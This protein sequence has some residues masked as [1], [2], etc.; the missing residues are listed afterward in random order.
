MLKHSF[1][2]LENVTSVNLPG[3]IK[4]TI[5]KRLCNGNEFAAKIMELAQDRYDASSGTSSK[6]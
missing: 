2:T 6:C 5:Y 1:G 3:K 4:G